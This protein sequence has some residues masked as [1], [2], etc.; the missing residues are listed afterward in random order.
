VRWPPGLPLGKARQQL[1][2]SSEDQM[3]RSRRP[4]LCGHCQPK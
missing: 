4:L 1:I 2:A 3:V